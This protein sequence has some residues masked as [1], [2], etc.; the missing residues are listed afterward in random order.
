MGCLV[1]QALMPDLQAAQVVP[2]AGGMVSKSS[3]Q[4][5]ADNLTVGHSLSVPLKK[6]EV[7]SF[8]RKNVLL[9]KKNG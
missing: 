2:I 1:D 6:A 4:L 5:L 7:S 3:P 8:K 9:E